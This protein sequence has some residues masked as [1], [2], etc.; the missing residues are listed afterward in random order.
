MTQHEA[1]LLDAGSG[2]LVHTWTSEAALVHVV[3]TGANEV[4]A[5]T[6]KGQLFLLRSSLSALECVG[7]ADLQAEVACLDI[8]S[9]TTAGAAPRSH[10][11]CVRCVHPGV[12][13]VCEQR[14]MLAD[15]ARLVAVGT[16][17]SHLLIL[18]A[19]ALQ[20][21]VDHDLESTII[22]RSTLFTALDD[23]HAVLVGMGDGQLAHWRVRHHLLSG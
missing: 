9:W 22:P 1:R 12:R 15:G 18:S 4:L 21:L 16:W 2:A 19:P 6:G 11:Q 3:S 10:A 17:S 13:N 20:V 14:G 8:A 23:G 7:Q 5:S